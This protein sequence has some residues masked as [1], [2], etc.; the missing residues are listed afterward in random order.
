MKIQCGLVVGV[1]KN[2]LEALVM[3][4]GALLITRFVVSP[5]PPPV[6]L[7]LTLGILGRSQGFRGNNHKHPPILHSRKNTDTGSQPG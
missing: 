4:K 1:E 6:V 3:P 2:C 7:F 5:P